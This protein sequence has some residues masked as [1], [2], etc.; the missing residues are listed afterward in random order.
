[1]IAQNTKNIFQKAIILHTFGGSGKGLGFRAQGW[2]MI[3]EANRKK[4]CKSSSG[5]FLGLRV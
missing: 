2:S 5:E 1:M 3:K 4:A